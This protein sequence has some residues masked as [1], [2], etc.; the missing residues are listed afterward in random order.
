MLKKYLFYLFI[1]LSA[2]GLVV[3]SFNTMKKEDAIVAVVESQKTA[4][5]YR[6]PVTIKAIHVSAGQKV[7][8]GDLLLEVERPDLALDYEKLINQ[9][10]QV[11]NKKN[12]L[13]TAYKNQIRLIDIEKTGKIE[14]LK[15]DIAQLEIEIGYNQTLR[16]NYQE[17]GISDSF[18][19]RSSNLNDPDSIKLKSYLTEIEQV[20]ALYSADLHKTKVETDEEIALLD[21]DI[22][23]INDEIEVLKLEELE[24]K[25][26]A[27]FD[28]TIGTV[29]GQINE[30]VPSFETIISLF[31][32]RPTTIKAYINTSS[33]F[34][35]SPGDS[36]YVE[37]SN[38]DYKTSGIVLE[39]GA[40]IVDFRNPTEPTTIPDKYGREIF[41][42]LP[43]DNSF[44]Y[45]EHV[46][47]FPV[48]SQ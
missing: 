20:S 11:E 23:L 19:Q 21:L 45:G 9:K 18:K 14:R 33:S 1:V 47:V 24:L 22:Q 32:E 46:F 16:S 10:N 41:I 38:R 15:A 28:G 39:V 42:K 6:K 37:S 34:S 12:N 26:T 4:L 48:K 44:L 8:K 17:L 31:E 2:I 25:K 13:R 43:E 27:P 36:V 40:R 35:L 29:N 3:V 7:K 5:S 30:I